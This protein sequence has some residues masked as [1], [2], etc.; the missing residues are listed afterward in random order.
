MKV[1]IAGLATLLIVHASTP[2]PGQ[3]S[4]QPSPVRLALV[5]VPDDVVRPM[6]PMFHASTGL[7]AGIVYTGRDPFAVAREGKADLVIAHY[8]HEGVEPFVTGGF[9]KWPHAVFANQTALLGPSRDP[10]RIRGLTDAA[11]ALRRIAESKSTFL[12]TSSDGG[13]YLEEILWIAAGNPAK[14]DWYVDGKLQGPEAARAAAKRGAYVLWGMPPF[15]RLKRQETIDLE[16]LVVGAS[17]LQRIMVSII[18]NEA[19]VTGANA[20]GAKAFEDFVL[21]PKT[22][23]WVR[24]F[25]YP[26]FD[27]Q[28]WWPSGRH[29]N[30][31]E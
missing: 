16:P 4:T 23:A 26:D 10:A 15:L 9:G 14:G 17:E 25:R 11:E 7:T 28:V 8:G 27:R 31:R 5:N 24:A 1:V 12:S 22:Q 3:S 29:N 20:H 30:A 19:K 13:K 2:T 18:V 6:L 21:A